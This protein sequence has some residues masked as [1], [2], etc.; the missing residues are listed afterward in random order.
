MTTTESFDFVIG[1]L[2]QDTN[3]LE[4]SMQF[5]NL[6]ANRDKR[7]QEI[8]AGISNG[9]I[10]SLAAPNILDEYLTQQIS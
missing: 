7:A 9:R 1:L 3:K 8:I 10:E 4:R 6:V 5:I 2:A